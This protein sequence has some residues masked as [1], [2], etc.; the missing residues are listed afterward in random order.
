M[1]E[2]EEVGITSKNVDEMLKSPNP[3]IKRI[4]GVIP[5]MGRALKVDDKWAYDIIKQVGNYGESYERNVGAGSAL[6]MPRALNALA[7]QG[8]MQYA[9]PM[10]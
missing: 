9:P 3:G 8:G 1:I 5:G 2:A 4:L 7:T 10:R 6:K